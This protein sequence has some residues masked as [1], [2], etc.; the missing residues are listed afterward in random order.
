MSTDIASTLGLPTRPEGEYPELTILDRNPEVSELAAKFLAGE[1]SAWIYRVS[2]SARPERFLQRY[3]QIFDGKWPTTVA[4]VAPYAFAWPLAQRGQATPAALTD[5]KELLQRAAAGGDELT[6]SLRGVGFEVGEG[7]AVV[8][9]PLVSP[10][11]A[12]SYQRFVVPVGW[13]PPTLPPGFHSRAPLAGKPGGLSACTLTSA[14]LEAGFAITA[15]DEA[16]YWAAADELMF[17]IGEAVGS[18]QR[19][20]TT[21]TEISAYSGQALI[22]L[23]PV[24]GDQRPDLTLAFDGKQAYRITVQF[25]QGPRA[26]LVIH[27]V[28]IDSAGSAQV[29]SCYEEYFRKAP[30]GFTPLGAWRLAHGPEVTFPGLAQ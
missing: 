1:P 8:T 17:L 5:G 21:V 30:R 23:V 2:T 25:P 4:D 15:P 28:V 14:L 12:A 22:N 3:L 29:T 10:S 26:D 13:A 24:T 11:G 27:W 9:R 19:L 6:P 16:R 20:P 7:G 18:A